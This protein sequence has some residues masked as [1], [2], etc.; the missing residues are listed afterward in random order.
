MLARCLVGQGPY[1]F[2]LIAQEVNGKE[3]LLRFCVFT[4]KRA[5]EDFWRPMMTT[6]NRTCLFFSL[7][8]RSL[9]REVV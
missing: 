7:E 1:K 8:A 3:I 9:T 5:I 4:Q 6:L 2:L